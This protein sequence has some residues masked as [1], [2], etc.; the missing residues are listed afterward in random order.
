MWPFF[1]F[2]WKFYFFLFV[3][4]FSIKTKLTIPLSI[5]LYGDWY[6]G[7][8][9]IN[10]N[11]A[12]LTNIHKQMDLYSSSVPNYKQFLNIRTPEQ[13]QQLIH[14]TYY[15]VSFWSPFFTTNYISFHRDH[16]KKNQ[17]KWKKEMKYKTPLS[18]MNNVNFN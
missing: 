9:E 3:L 12:W 6:P 8:S 16:E 2:I 5:P 11:N 14:R 1:P 13:L 18:L 4:F 17:T 7:F 15:F 10:K